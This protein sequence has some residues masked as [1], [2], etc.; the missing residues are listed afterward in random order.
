MFPK[1][2]LTLQR[3][4][5]RSLFNDVLSWGNVKLGGHTAVMLNLVG[6]GEKKVSET[7]EMLNMLNFGFVKHVKLFGVFGTYGEDSPISS[8]NPKKFNM[9]NISAVSL[10]FL[11]PKPTK[12]NI[13]PVGSKFS[14]KIVSRWGNVKL[15]GLK[16]Q[17]N[18]SRWEMLNMLNFLGPP[19][20]Y[21]ISSENPKKFNMFNISAVSLTFFSPKP[22]DVNISPV[23][24]IF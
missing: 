13:S 23:G 18:A 7:A 10:T 21:P 22:T 4:E 11:P 17:K 9:F 8:K 3:W 5:F 1:L 14:Q 15:C 24:I 6:F 20:P 19:R 12:F 2:C 16:R